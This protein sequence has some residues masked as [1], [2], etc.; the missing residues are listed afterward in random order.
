MSIFSR[1]YK[2]EKDAT[3][4]QWQRSDFRPPVSCSEC[5]FYKYSQRRKTIDN[6]IVVGKRE[7]DS[8]TKGKYFLELKG[9]LSLET[10]FSDRLITWLEV[11]SC[12][13][14]IPWNCKRKKNV[15]WVTLMNWILNQNTKAQWV[16]FNVNFKVSGRT[17]KQINCVRKHD[18]KS[19]ITGKRS[20][21]TRKLASICILFSFEIDS[22][23]HFARSTRAFHIYFHG[24]H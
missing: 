10:F 5:C 11:Y 6:R 15:N 16:N 18:G 9:Q 21:K 7:I 4:I 24:K 17:Y 13:K 20:R 2:N 22:S 3:L 8:I 1:Y 14:S 19:F 23:A 12:L